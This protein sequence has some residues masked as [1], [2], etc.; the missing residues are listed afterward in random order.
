[1]A[2]AGTITVAPAADSFVSSSHSSTNYGNG[3]SLRADGSPTRFALLKFPRPAGAIT[4]LKLRVHRV[5]G[6]DAAGVNIRKALTENWTEKGVTYSNRPGRSSTLASPA[7]RKGWNEI[8]LPVSTLN[9][10]GTTT[11]VLDRDG[12]RD[13]TLASR[14]SSYSAQLIVTTSDATPTPTPTPSATPTPAPSATPTPTPTPTPPGGCPAGSRVVTGG[15]IATEL[16]NTAAGGI[17]CLNGG[18][19]SVSAT[20]GVSKSVTLVGVN[21]PR[22]TQTFTGNF[23]QVS[24][25]N[26]TIQ[27]LTMTGA[28][29][30]RTG[31][32]CAGTG[33]I[34]VGAVAG[35][36]IV[37]NTADTFTCGIQLNG[38]SSFSVT[39]N[40]LSRVKYAAI[41]TFPATDG[42]ISGNTVT[43]LNVDGPLGQNA[44]GIVISGNLSRNVTVSNNM[45]NR[46]PTWECYDTHD[47]QSIDFLSNTCI[48][49]GRVGINHVNSGIADPSGRV[50]GNTIDAGGLT[51]QWNSIAFGG[52]GTVAN[53]VIKGFG[54]CMFWT[55]KISPAG[56][57]C[58]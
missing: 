3:V 8:S 45:V 2:S 11:I 4:A 27:G 52:Y 46:A 26:V 51:S 19:Y 17:L 9:A 6:S 58:S 22:L 55:P 43:D 54:S 42:V 16:A 50:E 56:N 30:N 20:I 18:S 34:R 36:K 38:T 32:S 53:N 40:R 25:A 1:M 15:S 7:V 10:S 49:P 13:V 47:G 44:Y 14:E 57:T 35:V 48:G 21:S 37:S 5:G 39:G 24:A 41:T 33:A 31:E 28:N 23:F 29:G 12:S